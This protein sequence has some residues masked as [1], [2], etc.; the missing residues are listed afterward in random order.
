M[1]STKDVYD[2]AAKA[3]GES[4]HEDELWS[5][6]DCGELF[7]EEHIADL[8]DTDGERFLGTYEKGSV[9]LCERCA[10]TRAHKRPRSQR[11]RSEE[12]EVA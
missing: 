2:C 5:C 3:C 11:D 4:L 7:C 12:R 1:G 8:L 10:L 6:N 9:F